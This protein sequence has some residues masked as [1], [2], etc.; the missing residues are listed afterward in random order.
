MEVTENKKIA[1]YA[2]EDLAMP[3]I[4]VLVNPVDERLPQITYN[5]RAFALIRAGLMVVFIIGSLVLVPFI[6]V[7]YTEMVA[8]N[9]DISIIK[10]ENRELNKK[11][12]DLETKIKP[13]IS[14]TRI[15]NTAKNRLNMVFPAKDNFVNIDDKSLDDQEKD[16]NLAYIS[17]KAN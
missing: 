4:D 9:S 12:E 6:V 11:V 15:E 2:S 5:K 1:S 13:F 17:S 16:E 10:Y 8:I 3:N 7:G 14:R